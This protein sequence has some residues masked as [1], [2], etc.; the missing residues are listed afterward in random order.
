VTRPTPNQRASR[1][2]CEDGGTIIIRRGKR[3]LHRPP[4][5]AVKRR[6]RDAV[7]NSS[8]PASPAERRA[9]LTGRRSCPAGRTEF[10]TSRR[11]RCSKEISPR[12]SNGVPCCT[13]IGPGRR[14]ALRQKWCTN[15]TNTRMQ[16]I[17]EP[18]RLAARTGSARRHPR[19]A[20][21]FANGQGRPCEQLSH[22]RSPQKVLTARKEDQD[23]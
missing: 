12:T 16:L 2:D 4:P 22:S 23:R 7:C 21:V 18:T 13:H 1:R 3:D 19:S 10:P 6:L 17:G 5:S 14:R 20:D 11:A 9:R 15:G 8:A